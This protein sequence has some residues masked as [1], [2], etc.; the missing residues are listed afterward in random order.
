M[1]SIKPPPLKKKT[2]SLLLD[3]RLW[4]LGVCTVTGQSWEVE[5]VERVICRC[6]CGVGVDGVVSV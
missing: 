6:W 4:F 2:L 5:Q 3:T 1:H